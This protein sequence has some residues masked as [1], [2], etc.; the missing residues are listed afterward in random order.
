MRNSFSS[1]IQYSSLNMA[2]IPPHKRQVKE[3]E[4]KLRLEVLA[5][6]FEEKLRLGGSRHAGSKGWQKNVLPFTIAPV[7]S[8]ELPD[9]IRLEPFL[10]PDSLD[11]KHQARRRYFV[12]HNVN[13]PKGFEFKLVYAHLRL[14]IGTVLNC[15]QLHV[16][17]SETT[18]CR[19]NKEGWLYIA[20][21]IQS[22]VFTA[23]QNVRNLIQDN[24]HIKLKSSF[25][26]RV[27][28][29]L[30]H[31]KES[32]SLE[33]LKKG[34]LTEIDRK[35]GVGKRFSTDVTKKYMN[36]VENKVIQDTGFTLKAQK[37][38][39]HLKI[40]D[41]QKPDCIFTCKCDINVDGKLQL[42]KVDLRII[43]VT[44][45]IVESFTAEEKESIMEVV[46]SAIIDPSVK[47]GLRW[48]LGKDSAGGR[49][50]VL[51]YF[52]M[53]SKSF[54]GQ[55]V[56]LKLRIADRF[57]L[58]SHGKISEEVSMKLIGLSK[59]F[60]EAGGGG[61]LEAMEEC[62]QD[63]LKLIWGNFICCKI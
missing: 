25:V 26:A 46:D 16:A 3:G 30:F 17:D 58:S 63:T 14:L 56:K 53:L 48:S 57:Y 10:D 35:S 11:C 44:K 59:H 6:K 1:S 7:E 38:Q 61:E 8:G 54:F 4:K 18:T 21:K 51:E 41:K 34:F 47:G 9:S 39:Y 15:W 31:S 49:F 28:K 22:D 2:Y 27:G 19:V 50:Y 33:K 5:P 62:L 20:E 40:E 29:I 52:H 23:F 13:E 60:K 36:F 45:W 32:I 24:E 43:L 42:K 55:T 37:D 12:L